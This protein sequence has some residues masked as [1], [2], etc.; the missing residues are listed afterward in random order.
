MLSVIKFN[1]IKLEMNTVNQIYLSFKGAKL[2]VEYADMQLRKKSTFQVPA[3]YPGSRSGLLALSINTFINPTGDFNK[4]FVSFGRKP[5]P[6][7][8]ILV[9]LKI[10]NAK[11]T[12]DVNEIW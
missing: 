2:S 8:I 11:T 1:D 3:V 12:N 7:Q 10:Y 9:H 5:V 6:Q 4:L